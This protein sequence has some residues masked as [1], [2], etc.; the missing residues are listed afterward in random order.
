MSIIRKRKGTTVDSKRAGIP[1]EAWGKCTN[2]RSSSPRARPCPWW[3]ERCPRT[4]EA[5]TDDGPLDPPSQRRRQHA[6]PAHGA[7]SQARRRG[8]VD[9]AGL[10]F[11]TAPCSTRPRNPAG[12]RRAS[13]R[14]AR[15]L[16]ASGAESF[17]IATEPP[18]GALRSSS[19]SAH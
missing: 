3:R 19:T 18:L 6:R 7:A 8:E 15:C 4:S 16:L 14:W 10:L 13:P 12:A 1:S 11:C 2:S 17:H 9:L 5:R